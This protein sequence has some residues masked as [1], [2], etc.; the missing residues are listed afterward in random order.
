MSITPQVMIET[1]ALH[2]QMPESRVK[3]YDRKLMEAGLRT[4]KGHGR[5]SALMTMNDAAM[6]LIAIASTDDVSD[7]ATTA[8]FLRDFPQRDWA[9]ADAP[10]VG[11]IGGRSR[12]LKKLGS[13]V[14]SIMKYLAVNDVH[15]VYLSLD[16]TLIRTVP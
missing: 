8:A 16:V 12:D 6:L 7:A 4:K 1:V 15:D 3:N 10:L 9:E 5:G 11:L 13:A 2:L 14:L